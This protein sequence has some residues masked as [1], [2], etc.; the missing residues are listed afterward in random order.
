MSQAHMHLRYSEC[1]K[2][3]HCLQTLKFPFFN[4]LL[5]HSTMLRTTIEFQHSEVVCDNNHD[6]RNIQM[7]SHQNGR[8]SVARCNSSKKGQI[9]NRCVRG[10]GCGCLRRQFPAVEQH[11]SAVSTLAH[12]RNITYTRVVSRDY[13]RPMRKHATLHHG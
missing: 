9:W 11:V 3:P 10:T 1:F 7:I 5:K 13:V 6:D 4:S 8:N 12:I 2:F